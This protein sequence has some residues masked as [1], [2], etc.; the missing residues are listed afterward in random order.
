MNMKDKA[1]EKTELVINVLEYAHMNKLNIANKEDVKK[2]LEI[3]AP[4]H[5]KDKDVEEFMGILQG[6]DTFM[7]MTARKNAKKERLSN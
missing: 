5:T 2:M 1:V 6:A 7:E 4:E 3:F